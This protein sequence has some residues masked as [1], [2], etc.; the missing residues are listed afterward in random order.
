[1]NG[2]IGGAWVGDV[3]VLA[4]FVG[5]PTSDGAGWK[6]FCWGELIG[7]EYEISGLDECPGGLW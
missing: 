5:D 7:C 2:D 1:M 3:L 6:F 4:F